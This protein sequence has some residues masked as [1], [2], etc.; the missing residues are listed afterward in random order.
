MFTTI[1]GFLGSSVFGSIL[2]VFGNWLNQR[3]IL[4]AEKVKNE[5][6]VMTQRQM[7]QLK[8]LKLR[9]KAQLI[10]KI[11]NLMQLILL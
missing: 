1:I 3:T 5:Q 2:G 8:L 4:K 6:E 11:Q 9:L 7:L 10:Y